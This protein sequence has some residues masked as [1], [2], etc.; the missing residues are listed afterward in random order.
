MAT[1]IAKRSLPRAP[2]T[3]CR[4]NSL[5]GRY[6]ASELQ[7]QS[8]ILEYLELRQIIHSVTDRSRHWDAKGRV[9]ASRVSHPGWPDISLVLPGGRAAFI[10]VKSSRGVVSDDQD[11][12]HAA[13]RAAGALVI[14]ARSLDD[15]VQQ[16][17]GK[18]GFG[19][20]I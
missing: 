8:T 13:L 5:P 10:E 12:C 15:V 2:G 16:L 19:S 4:G 17:P 3:R 9:R 6:R 20:S 14:V 18:H 7:I 11:A 1:G